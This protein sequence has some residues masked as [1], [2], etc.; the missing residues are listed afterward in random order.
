MR[1]YGKFWHWIHNAFNPALIS[2][3]FS[4]LIDENPLIMLKDD[5]EWGVIIFPISR[6]LVDDYDTWASSMLSAMTAEGIIYLS[7]TCAKADKAQWFID[8]GLSHPEVVE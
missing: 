2:P 1:Q 5:E 7:T 8:N 4:R 3:V 6:I